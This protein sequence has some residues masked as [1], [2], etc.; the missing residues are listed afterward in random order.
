MTE[1][2]SMHRGDVI[3]PCFCRPQPSS[4][5]QESLF[6]RRFVDVLAELEVSPDDLARWHSYDWLSF[7]GQSIVE[8]DD[9]GDPRVWELT[10]IRD[11]VRSGLS[12]A[13]VRHLIGRLPKPAAIDPCRFAYSFRFGWIEGVL[14]VDPD[15]D[16]LV[17]AH[18]DGWLENQDLDRLRALQASIAELV[19]R[20]NHDPEEGRT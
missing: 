6:K 15:P 17:E 19:R 9:V 10:V 7:D 14:P 18:I 2:P 12:D 1:Y 11:I 20:C 4:H 13:H 3:P 16:E 8:V 5:N